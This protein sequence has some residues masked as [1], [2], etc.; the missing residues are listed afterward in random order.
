MLSTT[1][2]VQSGISKAV[3]TSGQILDTIGKQFETNSYTEK[4]QPCTK[5][6]KLGSNIPKID[7]AFV[8][9]SA[10]VIG[11]VSIA[12]G[13][14]IWYGAVLRGDES[15][16]TVGNNVTI[17]DRCMVHVAGYPKELPT[18]IG[19][20]CVIEAGAILHGCTLAAN[21]LVG[22]GAQV[23]DGATV[24]TGAIVAAG[25]VV[26]MG[27]TVPPKQLWSGVPATYQRDLTEAEV[28]KIAVL[29]KENMLLAAVHA[30]ES[31]KDW[32]T[33]EEDEYNYEQ[34]KGRSEYYY[35]RLTPEELSER[36][37]E[38]E[39]HQVPGR[40]LDSP[41]SGHVFPEFRPA[42]PK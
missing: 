9:S 21:C 41:V 42:P 40:V 27:K 33:I 28:A 17:G 20:G 11:K 4:L 14:S 34:L 3:R 25:S 16:I 18:T 24:S 39:N 23:L 5:V 10:T 22:Q 29:A 35:Q 37:G 8:A 31:A 2:L 13:S 38:I 26:P 6:V 36:L 1:K 19:D 30:E 7:K 12:Q 32:K 15:N